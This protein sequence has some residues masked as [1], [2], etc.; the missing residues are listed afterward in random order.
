VNGERELYDL[1]IDP[2]QLTSQHANPAYKSVKKTLR[3]KLNPLKTCVG[4][5]CWL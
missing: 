4:A 1:A 3:Q 5:G 2:D